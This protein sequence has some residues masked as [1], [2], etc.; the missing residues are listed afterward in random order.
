ML[1]W[2]N[3][4]V[5]ATGRSV[6]RGAVAT[7]TCDLWHGPTVTVLAPGIP[8][9]SGKWC[10]G[11][12]WEERNEM[13]AKSHV[14][15]HQLWFLHLAGHDT[16]HTSSLRACQA[17]L[18]CPPTRVEEQGVTETV[19]WVYTAKR[20]SILLLHLHQVKEVVQLN[21]VWPAPRAQIVHGRASG[22]KTLAFLKHKVSEGFPHGCTAPQRWQDPNIFCHYVTS[23]GECAHSSSKEN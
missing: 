10:S 8:R 3:R 2:I 7:S 1:C 21:C 18:K 16:K 12:A 5:M 9:G 17:Q 14:K 22:T 23:W 20:P 15:A 4:E 11:S 19:V 6:Q 13:H